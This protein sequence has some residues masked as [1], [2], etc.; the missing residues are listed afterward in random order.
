[1][2][3]AGRVL[4]APALV[5]R[6][7][8]APDPEEACA[9]LRDLPYVVWLD[10]GPAGRPADTAVGRYS[11]LTADPAIVLRDRGGG[12]ERMPSPGGAWTRLDA[13]LLDAARAELA[14]HR[15]AAIEGLP[16]FQGGLAG[17]VGYECGARLERIAPPAAERDAPPDAVLGLYDWVLAWDHASGA[18]WIVSTGLPETGAAREARARH[19]IEVV[20]RRLSGEA[21]IAGSTGDAS[22]APTSAPPG[23]S[24]SA[25]RPV[26]RFESIGL[27]S[28]F[29]RDGYLA[30]VERVRA[31]VLDGDI[32]Q[33]NLSQRFEAPLREPAWEL[34]RRL[35]RRNPAPFGAYLELPD[36]AVL[37]V[38]P[39]R[40]VQLGPDG[41]VETRPIK[42]TR[43]RGADA[44][45][46]AA[47]AAELAASG[48]DRAENVMIV[49]LLRN[50]LAR[51]CE[52]GSVR[53][54][55][56]LAL[57]S[58]PTVHHLVSTVTGRL[59]PGHDAFDLLRA[60]LPGGSITGAPKVRAMEIIAEL[61]P[62][63][64]GVYCG[65]IGWIGVSGA[66]DTSVAIRTAVA[67]RGR[68]RFGAGGGIV[69]DSEP[70]A[71]YD[72][73]IAKARA[74]IEVLGA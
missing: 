9:R 4:T 14:P 44:A 6:L 43:P 55:S 29:T 25:G 26:P 56:L 24:P 18:A 70:A 17:Y 49:D 27:G 3:V 58:H 40:F 62:A 39:E 28:T 64:R 30:A 45:E 23:P 69:L 35:R 65:A 48:K 73:T 21:P 52:A 10:G 15:A 33:A 34:Y 19:R 37:S 7:A 54:P 12:V 32:F 16:P 57:E 20:L 72:E 61:E 8:P 2:G 11:Y 66:M 67:Q 68:I 71:E 46:D 38:S 1:V 53:V 22:A 50:D 13:D 51:V 31:Y 5:E 42:G 36:A 63:P 59:A 47:L 74:F 60:T 41:T